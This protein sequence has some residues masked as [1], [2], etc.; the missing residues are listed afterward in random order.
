M[1]RARD[2]REWCRAAYLGLSLPILVILEIVD[3]ATGWRSP[4]WLVSVLSL[5]GMSAALA[6]KILR[7]RGRPV[8]VG[9]LGDV[10]AGQSDDMP[11]DVSNWSDRG[12]R[13]EL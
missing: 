13:F 9:V 1:V 5:A 11:E 2:F 4:R 12:G 6:V 10:L 8:D 7:R 3:P